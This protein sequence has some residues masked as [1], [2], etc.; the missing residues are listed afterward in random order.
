MNE[1]QVKDPTW[2]DPI[3][4]EV[5]RIREQLFADAGYDLDEFVRR[6]RLQEATSGHPVVTCPPRKEDDHPERA[7]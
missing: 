1:N 7:G 5:R 2:E 6:L 4:A 3:V